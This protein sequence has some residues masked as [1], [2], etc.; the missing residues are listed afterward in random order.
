MAVS[1]L[2]A[3]STLAK[4]LAASAPRLKFAIKLVFWSD[5]YARATYGSGGTQ[6][7]RA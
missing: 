4:W 1:A 6:R 7:D 5:G 2:S 3:P